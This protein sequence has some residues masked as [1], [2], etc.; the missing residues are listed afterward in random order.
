MPLFLGDQ[1]KCSSCQCN[2]PCFSSYMS[3]AYMDSVTQF[4]DDSEVLFHQSDIPTKQNLY[5]DG[6]ST[7]NVIMDNKDFINNSAVDGL[8][9]TPVFSIL[10]PSQAKYVL[11]MDVSG[12]MHTND[13]NIPRDINMINAVKRWITYEVSDGTDVGMVVFSAEEKTYVF[14]NFVTIT[15]ITRPELTQNL[16]KVSF[17]G[18]TCI[19]KGLQMALE[20]SSLLNNGDGGVIILLTDGEQTDGCLSIG[21]VQ[22]DLVDHKVKVVSIALGLK[23]DPAIEG[24]ALST[25]GKSYYVDDSSGPGTFNDAFSGSLTYQPPD[26]MA[27]RNFLIFQ[28]DWSDVKQDDSIIQFFDIDVSIGRDVSFIVEVKTEG[29]FNCNK[30]VSILIIKPDNTDAVKDTFNCSTPNFGVY[31]YGFTTLAEE[32][33]W[34][35]KITVEEDYKDVSVKVESKSRSTS[36]D[37]VMSNCW[38]STGAQSLDAGVDVK[39]AVVADVSQGSMPVLGAVVEAEVERSS[40]PPIVM[41][42]WDNGSGADKIKNDGTYS[43]YFAHYSG[44]GRFSVKCQVRGDGN[45]EANGGFT[46]S[47]RGKVYP[48]VHQPINPLCCGSNA[49]SPGAN[50]TKTGNFSRQAAG[51][52]FQTRGTIRDQ[53]PPVRVTDLL[54]EIV[55]DDLVKITFTAPGDDLDSDSPATEYVIKYSST[56]GNLTTNFDSDIYNTR[57]Q[58]SDLFNSSLTPVNGG[59][60][61]SIT[62]TSDMFEQNQKYV[63]ALRSVDEV[64]NMS[65]VSNIGQLY[66]Q[67]TIVPHCP[68][69]FYHVN[70]EDCLYFKSEDKETDFIESIIS[71]DQ[72][73]GFLA[74]PKTVEELSMLQSLV[75]G[76]QDL[77]GP[78]HWWLGLTD[79]QQEGSWMWINENQNATIPKEDWSLGRPDAELENRN[80]CVFASLENNE[81]KFY[82]T[83]C[84]HKSYNQVALAPLCQ[85]Q[86]DQCKTLKPAC[87]RGYL[88]TETSECLYII[89]ENTN[90]DYIESILACEK[91]GGFLAE[92][93]TANDVYALL[94]AINRTET[95]QSWWIGLSDFLEEGEW[96]WITSNEKANGEMLN[97]FWAAEHPDLTADNK[98]DCVVVTVVDD[99]LEFTDV[100]CTSGAVGGNPVGSACQCIPG[101][102][103]EIE[104]EN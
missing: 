60:I 18:T 61:V 95:H 44:S 79:M 104:Q 7:W 98:N 33:R 52:S 22:Q 58:D 8:D 85:C 45:T 99:Q 65:P 57:I 81:L 62:I 19:G 94:R 51:G 27:N 30:P 38:I 12:S 69:N 16:D 34:V 54:I 50:L 68:K 96:T 103:K 40:G 70:S 42:L 83:L 78:Q 46:G 82:D 88:Q 56:S 101:Q 17:G 5:C 92:L 25:G 4:C 39:I 20:D 13:Q 36:T 1:I 29:N 43:R 76:V 2:A 64:G 21:D 37:P 73:G 53:T 63:L 90:S 49:L 26:V 24:L 86:A 91:L 74:E 55:E 23:A 32:G 31:K 41:E 93:K 72:L 89:N 100:L 11:V 80:D 48:Q 102:C 97:T 9:T 10:R 77:Y 84:T 15:N 67:R 47:R 3:L 87:P 14:S 6:K 75:L 71:C 35:F 66:I 28:K 59:S